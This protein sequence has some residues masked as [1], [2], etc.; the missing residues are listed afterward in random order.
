MVCVDIMIDIRVMWK[1][2]RF[3][4]F[5]IV[6]CHK[7]LPESEITSSTGYEEGSAC[8]VDFHCVKEAGTVD[9]AKSYIYMLHDE[10]Y[11]KRSCIF[12]K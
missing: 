12:W 10:N 11:A 1:L 3:F 7:I 2:I 9:A 8:S 5:K 6:S 4:F